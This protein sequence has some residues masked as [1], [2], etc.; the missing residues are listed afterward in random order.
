MTTLVQVDLRSEDR[1]LTCW[2]EPRVKVGDVITLK[3]SQQPGRLWSVT[4]VGEPRSSTAIKRGWDF[5]YHAD[6]DTVAR[7][8]ANLAAKLSTLE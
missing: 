2:V 1:V 7:R 8:A 4:R 6:A 3:N 5:D